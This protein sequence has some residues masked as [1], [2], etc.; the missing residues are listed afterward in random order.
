MGNQL[1]AYYKKILDEMVEFINDQDKILV[2]KLNDLDDVRLAMNCLQNVRENFIRIDMALTLMED[3]YAMFHS[4]NINI[5]A[6]DIERVD[7]LRFNF[8]NM[9]TKVIQAHLLRLLNFSNLHFGFIFRVRMS[10]QKLL[11]CKNLCSFNL[12]KVSLFLRMKSKN[13]IL[14]LK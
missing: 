9:M 12:K 2:R 5:P 3:T 8:Q 6:A 11:H 10:K 14:I 1:S 4:F 13:L 7:G